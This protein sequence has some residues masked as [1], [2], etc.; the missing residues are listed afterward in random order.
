M[1]D[2]SESS[3]ALRRAHNLSEDL[4][5]ADLEV[6]EDETDLTETLASIKRKYNAKGFSKRAVRRSFRLQKL[7]V[8]KLSSR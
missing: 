1:N 5:D 8:K 3:L 7:K 2:D 6:L 4:E